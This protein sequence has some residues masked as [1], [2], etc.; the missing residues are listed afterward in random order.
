MAFATVFDES[1]RP[2]NRLATFEVQ[3]QAGACSA[4]ERL[5][6]LVST[7]QPLALKLRGRSRPPARPTS[8]PAEING[9]AP[10]LGNRD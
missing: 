4:S 7:R 6:E 10:A 8:A 3:T 9:R 5:P 1:G 2:V